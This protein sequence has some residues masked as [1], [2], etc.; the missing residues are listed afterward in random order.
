MLMM[1]TSLEDTPKS[2]TCNRSSIQV[3]E[4]KRR[5]TKTVWHYLPLILLANNMFNIEIL[6]QDQKLTINYET[7]F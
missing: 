2:N 1:M 4:T 7:I 5:K 3:K 6:S